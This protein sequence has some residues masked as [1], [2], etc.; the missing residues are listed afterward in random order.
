VKNY[1]GAFSGVVA[2][3]GMIAGARSQFAAAG[4]DVEIRLLADPKE[5]LSLQVY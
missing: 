4:L 2:N 3:D 1:G 5:R